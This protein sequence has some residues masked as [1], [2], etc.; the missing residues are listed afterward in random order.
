MQAHLLELISDPVL[1]L[2]SD[3]SLLRVNPAARDWL[4]HDPGEGWVRLRQVAGSVLEDWLRACTH[5]LEVGRAAPP[6]PALA[7]AAVPPCAPDLAARPPAV[8]PALPARHRLRA[9]RSCC[10]RADAQAE[11][12]AWFDLCADPCCSPTTVASSCPSNA[13]F[14][15]LCLGQPGSMHETSPAMQKLL[16]WT[17]TAF[18]GETPT[19]GPVVDPQGRTRW[20]RV[21]CAA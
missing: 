17:V 16:G 14:Q 10:R 2:R 18:G 9:P 7:W 21:P 11:L 20:L 13:A 8:A 15:A 12:A 19:E 6:A 3:L 4:G 5:A 1:T